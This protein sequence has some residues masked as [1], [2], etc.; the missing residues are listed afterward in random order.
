MFKKELVKKFRTNAILLF[1]LAEKMGLRI[2]IHAAVD[3][4]FDLQD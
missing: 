1:V 4:I 2:R 3:A